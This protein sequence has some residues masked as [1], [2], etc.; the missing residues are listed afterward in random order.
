MK[1]SVAAFF[2]FLALK[3]GNF[4]GNQTP[5]N[6]YLFPVAMVTKPCT[7][8][9]IFYKKCIHLTSIYTTALLKIENNLFLMGLFESK[10]T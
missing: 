8:F 2:C 9:L 7:N 5:V 10:I 4:W 6:R 1:P 3:K